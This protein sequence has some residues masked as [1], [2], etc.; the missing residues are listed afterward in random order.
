M[1][2]VDRTSVLVFV[3]LLFFADLGFRV[4]GLGF[5]V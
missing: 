2:L 1:V 4:W 3:G 5:G